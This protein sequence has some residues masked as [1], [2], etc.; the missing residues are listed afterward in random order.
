MSGIIPYYGPHEPSRH[1]RPD[2]E[3]EDLG[4]NQQN[5]PSTKAH[6]TYMTAP[7]NWKI[8]LVHPFERVQQA[9]QI[10]LIPP[11]SRGF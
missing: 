7:Y 4:L 3:H 11:L 10:H 2:A 8:F 1:T 5:Q 6:T 9:L